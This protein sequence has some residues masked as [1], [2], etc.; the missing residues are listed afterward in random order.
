MN[1]LSALSSEEQV[2]AMTAVARAALS[3]WAGSF[4]DLSLVKYRENAV[5]HLRRD[6][7]DRFALRVHR[8]GYH[9]DAELTS[10]LQW[11]SAL[12]TS[13]FD[14]PSVVPAKDGSLFVKA[15]TPILPQPLQVDMLVWLEGE[16]LGSIETGLSCPSDELSSLYG[17]VGRLAACL[18][19]QSAGWQFPAGFSRHAW[20]SRGLLGPN[21]FWGEFCDLA[22]LS[23][24]LS[25][26][27]RAC[28]NAKHDL[29][30]LGRSAE[31][32]GLIHADLVP[33]NILRSNHRLMLIDFDDAGFGWHMFELATALFWYTDKPYYGTIRDALLAGYRSV[34]PLPEPQWRQ[35]PLFLF[36]RS[37]TYLGWI[38]TRSETQIALELTPMLIER[39]VLSAKEYLDSADSPGVPAV[40]QTSN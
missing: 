28:Q 37:L 23:D 26:I 35:L 14:A 27:E 10:E 5:F 11:M 12:A 1:M 15:T 29:G 22:A 4:E 21:P 33:E 34:R 30:R 31:N 20:D 40:S 36:L 19:D 13:G 39:A 7:G 25:L 38:R 32:Y 3:R 24:H 17:Q 16:P 6:N 2:A 18:H 9:T 8:I